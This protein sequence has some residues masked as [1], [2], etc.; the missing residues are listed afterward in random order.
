[1]LQVHSM[2]SRK[3]CAVLACRT[4]EYSS[5]GQLG[6]ATPHPSAPS[7]PCCLAHTPSPCTPPAPTHSPPDRLAAASNQLDSVRLK[8]PGSHSIGASKMPESCSTLCASSACPRYCSTPGR[9]GKFEGGT[10]G[11]SGAFYVLL[12]NRAGT[13]ALGRVGKSGGCTQGAMSW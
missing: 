10:E 12:T 3:G 1:M 11:N 8:L 2:E 6:S 5:N 4:L 9:A 13:A 7:R